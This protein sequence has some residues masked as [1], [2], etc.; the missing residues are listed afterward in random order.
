MTRSPSPPFCPSPPEPPPAPHIST[1]TNDAS[2]GIMSLVLPTVMHDD[3]I[4]TY[5]VNLYDKIKN[6]NKIIKRF[7]VLFI[8]N[9]TDCPSLLKE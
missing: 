4:A 9:I 8:R 6:Y 1:L 7:F 2:I 3:A 5:F